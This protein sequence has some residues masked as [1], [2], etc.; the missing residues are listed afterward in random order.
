MLQKVYVHHYYSKSLFYKIAHNTTNRKY[1]LDNTI[2]S[3]FCE[4]N[5]KNIEFIFNPKMNDNIDGYHLIDFLSIL[6]QIEID[7]KFKTIECINKKKG[8]NAH[9]GKWGAEF[10]INDVPIMKWISDELESKQNWI[11]FLLR[12]EKSFIQYDMPQYYQIMDLETQILRL[13]NH[14][15]FSDNYFINK[16]IESKYPNHNFVLTNTIHQWNELLSIRWYYEFK[17]V[18]EKIIPPYDLCFSMRYHKKNRTNLITKLAKLK[19]NRIFLSRTDNC[20]NN[21]FFKEDEELK[22]YE[23]I[24]INKWYGDNFDDMDWIENIEHYLDYIMRILPMAKLHIL[25]ETWDWYNGELSS[26][27]LSEKTYGLVLANIPFIATHTYPLDILQL[28]LGVDRYPFYEEV[29]QSIGDTDKFVLFIN[30]FFENYEYNLL[31]CKNWTYS[32]HISLINK[33]ESENSFLNIIDNL[34]IISKDVIKTK[35]IF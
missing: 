4:Y 35:K 13:K 34:S 23:N 1:H 14:H 8:D 27:Y 3:V 21:E 32:C 18:Y 33:I 22:K 24:S 6:E 30:K 29:Y 31:L 11:V 5:K 28:E 9:R 26:N 15:I 17:N 20:K 7:D 10:G 25:S 12:T 19:N 2:G 16:V